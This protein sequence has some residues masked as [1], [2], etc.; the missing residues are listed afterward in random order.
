MRFLA[1]LLTS[2]LVTAYAGCPENGAGLFSEEKVSK[3]VDK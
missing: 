2:W 3:E 1:N